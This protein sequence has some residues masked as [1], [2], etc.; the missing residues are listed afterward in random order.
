MN[1]ITITRTP[2]IIG[3]EIRTLTRQAKCLT[4]WYGVE[5]GRRLCEAKEL[6]GHGEWLNYLAE[7]TEFSQPSASRFMKLFTEYGADQG[8]LFGAET[9]YSTLNNLSVSNALRLL[10]IPEEE[11]ESFAAEID[12]EHISSRELEKAIAERD[13]ALRAR[14]D[15]EAKLEQA[16]KIAAD[17]AA[18]EK[19]LRQKLADAK[20]ALEDAEEQYDEA[21]A[22]SAETEK[23]LRE[24]IKELEAR[25]I[26]T[27][28]ERDEKAIAEAVT[29]A[30]ADVNAKW[31]AELAKANAKL[32]KAEKAAEKA[33]KTAEAAENS[34]AEKLAAAEAQAKAAREQMDA[35]IAEKAELAKK[36]AMSNT[37]VAEFKVLF[38]A[39]QQ[40]YS[41]LME[42]LAEI[43]CADEETAG[44]LTA[45]VERLIAQMGQILKGEENNNDN[46]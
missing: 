13:A 17:R 6:V 28:Y 27:V 2:E 38:T 32:D 30:T 36:L 18:V 40:D 12:A 20:E 35:A 34:T 10:A 33:K 23:T 29:K 4:L 25:P 24:K 26:E 44:K 46:D 1:E 9:K 22:E 7:N 3:A 11:R 21:Y 42:K 39:V 15:A 16:G 37:G 31:E 8:S 19:E 45:A 43:R 41:K 5:I 14:Q